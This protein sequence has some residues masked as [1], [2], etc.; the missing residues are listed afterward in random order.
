MR[1]IKY[2]LIY[3]SGFLCV[4]TACIR[5]E[6]DPER[7]ENSVRI[8]PNVAVPIGYIKFRLDSM[9]DDSSIPDLLEIHKDGTMTVRNSQEVYSD[10]ISDLFDFS[11]IHVP[12]VITNP[13][14]LLPLDQG[15]TSPYHDEMIPV[16]MND[17]LDIELYSIWMHT[18]TLI[19]KISAFP[20]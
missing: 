19:P 2:V 8:S 16:V 14:P 12:L 20:D 15:Y 18:H 9:L 13:L 4:I 6:F 5:E 1:S 17:T 10:S 7:L 3:L 11:E